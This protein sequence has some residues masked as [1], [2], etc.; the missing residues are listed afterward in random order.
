MLDRCRNSDG[1]GAIYPAMQYTVMAMEALGY[2]ADHPDFIEARAQFDKLIKETETSLY[3]QPCFSP[4]WDTAYSA[5]CL[6]ESGNPNEVA[7][8]RSADWL[9]DK[10]IRRRG[11][12][13]SNV[14]T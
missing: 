8:R 3:F 5:F 10:E 1:L 4:V 6:A 12:G 2:P 14:R 11:T 7:L 13:R 9:M